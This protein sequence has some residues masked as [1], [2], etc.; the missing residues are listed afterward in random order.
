MDEVYDHSKERKTVTRCQHIKDEVD[1][2]KCCNKKLCDNPLR[3]VQ[4][5][6]DPVFRR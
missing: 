1:K 4:G 5:A 6:I 2:P 3:V